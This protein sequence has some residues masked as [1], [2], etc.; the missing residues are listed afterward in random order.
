MLTVTG[1]LLCVTY[2]LKGFTYTHSVFT[3]PGIN[4]YCC[5]HLSDHRTEAR[6]I[7]QKT[8]KVPCPRPRSAQWQSRG[9][10]PGSSLRRCALNHRAP[11]P[12]RSAG[13]QWVGRVVKSCVTGWM[14]SLDCWAE[15]KFEEFYEF[16]LRF[17]FKFMNF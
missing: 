7:P 12:L 11:R 10:N 14:L 16:L 1:H 4:C 15:R 17:F 3:N 2:S 6:G 5:P 9:R 8:R 13:G